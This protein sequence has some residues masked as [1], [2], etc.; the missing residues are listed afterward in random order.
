MNS[1]FPEFEITHPLLV[2]EPECSWSA[3]F[4]LHEI[5]AVCC[6]QDNLCKHF[7]C[8]RGCSISSFSLCDRLDLLIYLIS[9]WAHIQVLTLT[10]ES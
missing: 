10:F 5:A 1:V 3:S 6:A 7:Y 8:F 4:P 9:L 2:R